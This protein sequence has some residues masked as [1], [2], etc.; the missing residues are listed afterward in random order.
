MKFTP[1][2]R[3]DLDVEAEGERVFLRVR[4]TGIGIAPDHRDYLFK[5]FWQ[6]DQSFTRS[7]GGMGLG[8]SVSR[9]LA[10]LLG[11]DITAES[12]PG[13]GSTFTLRLPLQGAGPTQ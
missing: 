4:D 11:G 1:K 13:K 6:A 3:V 9:R 5:P 8:L 12:V 2:G 10:R 7:A